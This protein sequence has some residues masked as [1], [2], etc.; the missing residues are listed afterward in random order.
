MNNNNKKTF[1]IYFNEHALF[2]NEG[3]TVNIWAGFT[4]V[5]KRTCLF[6]LIFLEKYE[7]K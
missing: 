7:V 2:I 4:M 3:A 5:L 1:P 6:N